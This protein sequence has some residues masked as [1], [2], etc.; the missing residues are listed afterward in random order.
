[1]SHS[2]HSASVGRSNRGGIRRGEERANYVHRLN[3]QRHEAR[4][5]RRGS[6]RMSSRTGTTASTGTASSGTTGSRS[7]GTR[8]AQ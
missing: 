5:D 8:S 3:S 1:M 4:E 7:A 6:T 2:S